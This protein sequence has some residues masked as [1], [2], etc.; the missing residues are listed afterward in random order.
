[1]AASGDKDLIQLVSTVD[2]SA[3][4][5]KIV[6][7]A[8]VIAATPGNAIGVLLNKPKT[9]ESMSVAFSG[10]MKAYAGGA[11]TAGDRVTVTT[12]GF[13]ITNATSVS[14]IVGKAINTCTSGSLVEFIGDFSN[15][16]TSYSVGIV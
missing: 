5:Y 16:R 10:H 12:S 4:Q 7:V 2:A 9:G 8:G 11:V 3:N 15:V 13:L 1:M 6:D 14:G